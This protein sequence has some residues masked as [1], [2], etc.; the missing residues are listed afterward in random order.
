MRMKKL[1]FFLSILAA[2]Q[3]KPAIAQS[4]LYLSKG[5]TEGCGNN[6]A[7][8]PVLQ[9][10]L[11]TDPNSFWLGAESDLHLGV[12]RVIR[13]GTFVTNL[14]PEDADFWLADSANIIYDPL[15]D[16]F[17]LHDFIAMELRNCQDNTIVVS[18]KIGYQLVNDIRF[19]PSQCELQYMAPYGGFP[20]WL[21]TAPQ[22]PIFNN[23]RPGISPGFADPYNYQ[24]AFNW[25][26][27]GST[28]NGHTTI[29]VGMNVPAGINQGINSYPDNFYIPIYIDD[30][31]SISNPPPGLIANV[32][33]EVPGAIKMGVEIPAIPAPAA[34]TNALADGRV[35]T[36]TQSQGA[37]SYLIKRE[38]FEKGQWHTDI[39][40]GNTVDVSGSPYTDNTALRG[41]M[42][43]WWIYA[44]NAGGMS[45][46]AITNKQKLNR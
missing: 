27:I 44:K 2:C 43:R 26:N 11:I 39:F 28:P 33:T 29:Y 6:G 9:Y 18:Q 31:Y 32:F 35:I 15:H 4:D 19:F 38:V 12:N 45:A 8:R 41:G 7:H 10:I 34:V 25:I 1:I 46:P 13:V 3:S 17:H 20:D 36:F 42:Y 5:Y 37:C 14:G 16:H 23:G 21:R 30:P 40:N 24:T 22:N